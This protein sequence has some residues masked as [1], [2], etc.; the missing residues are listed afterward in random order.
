M[1]ADELATSYGIALTVEGAAEIALLPF[2]RLRFA[3]S[4]LAS[5]APDGP[6]LAEG[7]GLSL[8]LDL[9]ALITG[10]VGL[11]A[12]SLDGAAITLPMSITDRR[13]TGAAER[14]SRRVGGD[15]QGELPRLNLTRAT[16]TGWNPRNAAI[17]TLHDVDLSL[18][19]PLLGKSAEI[20]ARGT[21]KQQEATL[22]V[23]GLDL[24]AL[25]GNVASPFS[26]TLA[27]PAGT[28]DLKGSARL[29]ETHD[30]S[31]RVRLTTRSLP[32][33]LGWTGGDVAL[34]PLMQDVAVEA[35]FRTQGKD[36]LLPQMRVAL[37]SN[38]LEGAGSVSFAD[39]RPAIQATLAAESV[40][41]APLVSELIGALGLD[42]DAS[43][44]PVWK[45]R[46][47]ALAP[48]TGGDLDLR[49]S[50]ASARIGPVLVEDIASSLIVR[51]GS[52]EA[53]LG[54]AGLQGGTVKGRVIL[55]AM[56]DRGGIEVKAQGAFDGL[57]LGALLIDMGEYR[58]L[59]GAVNGTF[60][61]DSR[62][63]TMG[64]LVGSI[65]GR[66]AVAVEGGTITGLDLAEVMQRDGVV[67]PPVQRIGRTDFARAGFALRFKDGLGSITEGTLAAPALTASLIGMVSLLERRFDA[68]A[69]LTPSGGGRPARL[70]EIVGPWN[71]IAVRAMADR[72]AVSDPSGLAVMRPDMLTAPNNV[73]VP[74]AARAYVP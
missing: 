42:P 46:T 15:R 4:R 22:R 34:A 14:L 3:Q 10:R 62:A 44:A 71:A 27:W 66:A 60:A 74:A 1:V 70:F 8:H 58:W 50:A 29:G 20:V 41:I 61:L 26:A 13:W 28:L 21:W 51:N 2:P 52:I 23:T 25:F 24:A 47:L 36:L 64:E 11:D 39:E 43:Q 35:D 31:G 40:N 7:G 16:V 73:G 5:G 55:A 56:P 59:V 67:G 18:S 54:R 68:R 12:L 65:G 48:F 69:E 49:L 32:E 6:V 37:G 63:S 19:A 53:S 57:D 33:T 17:Q 72:G 38:K 9:L 30:V 45:Q